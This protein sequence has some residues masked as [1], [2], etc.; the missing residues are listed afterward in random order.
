MEDYLRELY[1]DCEEY[2][3]QKDISTSIIKLNEEVKY[4]IENTELT[5]PT[6]VCKCPCCGEINYFRG[7]I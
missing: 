4:T 3:G 6:I 5:T 2:I 7:K 1:C